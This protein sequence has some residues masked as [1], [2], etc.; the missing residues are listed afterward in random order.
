MNVNRFDRTTCRVTG[1]VRPAPRLCSAIFLILWI[2][3]GLAS[4]LH[5][6]NSRFLGKI[7]G[8]FGSPGAQSI[9]GWACESGNAAPLRVQ[10][11]T[12]G[13]RGTGQLYSG[14][15]AEESPGDSSV[16]HACGTTTG[17]RFIIDINGDLLSRAGQRVYVSAFAPNGGPVYEVEGS[18]AF[19]I[20]AATTAG[21]LDSIDASGNAKGWAFDRSKSGESIRV[22]IYADGKSSMGAESGKLVW[23][24]S[25]DLPRPGVDRTYCIAGNHGFSVQLPSWVTVGPHSLSA[26]AMNANGKIDA[27][28]ANSPIVPGGSMLSTHISFSTTAGGFPSEWRGYKLPPGQLS[29]AALSGTVTMENSADIFS[30]ILFVVADVPT[31][32]CPTA[33]TTAPNGPPG[34]GPVLWSDI[35]K[36]PTTGSFNSPVNFT[37]PAGIP[38]SHCLLVGLGGGTVAG[39]HRVNAKLDLVATY[40]SAPD[41]SVQV[42]G[43]DSEFCFGQNW[44]CEGA[45]TNDGQSF[46]AVTPIT[47]RS[48]LQAIWGNISD[49]T[50]DGSSNFG[51]L[52]T[53]PWTAANDVYLYHASDCAQFPAGRS[54]NGPG[55]FAN[56]IPRD[57]IHLLTAPLTGSGGV[58][59]GE[60]INNLLPGLT[61]G[62]DVYK[63]FSDVTLNAGECLVVLYSVEKTHGAFDNEDQL[64]AIVTTF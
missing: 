24:G 16:S 62:I 37:L 41:N 40:I 54:F 33:G 50:F 55:D 61:N 10:L 15:S 52:P 43:L 3:V 39:L 64:H 53:R 9:Q 29:L 56:R 38:I 46:A 59:A 13:A 51:P 63:T 12:G 31:G 30:E 21:H 11:F 28:L 32:S 36:G 57:A 20:P 48:N 60:T 44:G 8:I 2:C 6:Q 42:L 45:T 19:T 1:I 23:E 58:G 25:A 49:S 5:A 17:H 47:Q 22:A 18:G 14:F 4:N 27:P 26:Y 35:I 34:A 7:E